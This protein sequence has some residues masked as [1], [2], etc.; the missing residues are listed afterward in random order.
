MSANSYLLE[1]HAAPHVHR[2]AGINAIMAQVIVALLPLCAFSTWQFGLS[3]PALLVTTLG[4][5]LATEALVNRLSGK[6]STIG[7]GSAAI[8][9][10]LLGLTLPPGLPLW[11][12]ALGGVIAMALGK[13]LFG[14]LGLNPFNPAL[15][16][17]AFLQAAYPAALTTW[18]P[19]FLKGRFAEFIPSSLTAP[20]C[21]APA[22]DTWSVERAVDGFSGATPLSLQKFHHIGTDTWDLL[23]GGT[24][25]STGETCALLIAAA[26][27]FLIL[28]GVVN[29]RIPV[30]VLGSAFLASLLVFLTN[31]A[32]YP[33]PVF[34]LFSGGLMLG[35]FFM[36]TDPVGS[37]VTPCGAW[38]YGCFI[39]LVTI[40]I[41]LKGGQP[42]GIMY[43]ILLGNAIVPLVERWTQPRI[44]GQGR[45]GH[46]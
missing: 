14:G 24:A 11:M 12:A 17:R 28:R 19:P 44:L 43:A 30:A 34:V 20:F 26:G 31:T 21:A 5:C 16:G 25:G 15:V 1:L 41:R 27:L 46:G 40:A 42:E 37:P 35:A 45:G 13:A 22:T 18:T 23:S 3:V 29:W 7:D 4:A 8:T 6:P 38:V 9:G 2:R 32:V 33:S 36:A 10:L 39:G